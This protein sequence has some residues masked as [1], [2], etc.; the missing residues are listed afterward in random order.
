M[1]HNSPQSGFTLIELIIV[2]AI[3]AILSTV[4]FLSFSSYKNKKDIEF[5]LN[6]VSSVVKE[7]RDRSITQE[8]GK[9]WGVRFNSSSTAVDSYEIFYGSSYSTSSVEDSWGF[10]RP[11]EFSEP[12]GGRTVDLTF[13]AITGK[14]DNKKIISIVHKNNAGR[15]GDIVINTLGKATTRLEDDIV[16]YW[17]FDEGTGTSTLDASGNENDGELINGPTWSSASDC[18]AGRCLDFDVD[19]SVQQVNASNGSGLDSQVPLTLMAWIYPE[20]TGGTDS[21]STIIKGYDPSSY[22]LSY[23]DTNRALD[24]YWYETSPAGYHSTPSDSV[25]LNE[26]SHIACV[27]DGSYLYQYVNGELKKTTGVTGSGRQASSITIGAESTARQFDG[28]IDEV[29]IYNTALSSSTVKSIYDD[30][31]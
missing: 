12:S 9:A 29:R 2:I 22:Y 25:S 30:L 5:S 1:N 26:W 19:A 24:C 15:V 31:K 3:G 13:E 14:I 21:R 28:L 23:N 17:H 6:E 7:I 4:G 27:W 18:K 16:G 10:R 8:D 11:V 20:G